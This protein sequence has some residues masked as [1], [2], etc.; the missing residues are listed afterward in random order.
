MLLTLLVGGSVL[1]QEGK[2]TLV[3]G[4]FNRV[5]LTQFLHQVEA[6]TP[7]YFYYDSTQVDSIEVSL[8]A[9]GQPLSKVLADVLK[10]TDMRFSIDR[11]KRVYLTRTYQIVTTLPAGFTGKEGVPAPQPPADNTI[12]S[13]ETRKKVTTTTSENRLYE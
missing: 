6:Q 8:T 11:D 12:V 5:K 3:T 1:A 9:T 7:Y 10:G 13:M 2:D 4:T